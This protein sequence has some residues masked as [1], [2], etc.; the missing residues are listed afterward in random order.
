MTLSLFCSELVKDG[1]GNHGD[2]QVDHCAGLSAPNI[3]QLQHLFSE[4]LGGSVY[5][6][7]RAHTLDAFKRQQCAIKF[8]NDFHGDQLFKYVHSRQHH[9]FPGYVHQIKVTNPSGLGKKLRRLTKKMEMLSSIFFGLR[10]FLFPVSL[11]DLLLFSL[12]C[13]T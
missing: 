6:Q 11:H 1:R 9:S 4:G 12:F 7:R 8:F 2:S 13:F 10:Y 5:G 3:Q